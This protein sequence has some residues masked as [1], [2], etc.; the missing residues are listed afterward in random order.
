VHSRMQRR[1]A[2]AVSARH[3]TVQTVQKVLTKVDVW[4][5]LT[6]IDG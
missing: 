6:P 1:R 3:E 4:T 5:C 2:R